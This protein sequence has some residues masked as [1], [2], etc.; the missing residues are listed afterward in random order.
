M[1]M[2]CNSMYLACLLVFFAIFFLLQ[3]HTQC[4][5]PFYASS[6]RSA[7]ESSSGISGADKR[8]VLATLQRF[9]ASSS[10]SNPLG[11]PTAMD[12]DGAGLGEE[13]LQDLMESLKDE[14][15]MWDEDKVNKLEKELGFDVRALQ[16]VMEE[17]G[18]ADD[19]DGIDE[20]EEEDGEQRGEELDELHKA[21]AGLD[22]GESRHHT[23]LSVI[24]QSGVYPHTARPWIDFANP[25]PPRVDY[26]I[27]SF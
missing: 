18:M 7:L 22:V 20:G 14:E 13:G 27:S 11:Q 15:G 12:P 24:Y 25:P 6:V 23:N 3:R 17:N 19:A 9:E 26:F 21:L 16:M 4:S 5:E 10:R 1:F 2:S 8:Q